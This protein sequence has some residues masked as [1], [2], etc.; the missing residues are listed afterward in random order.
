MK[1]KEELEKPGFE[2]IE[3]LLEDDK[4]V[5]IIKTKVA[6]E[7]LKIDSSRFFPDQKIV[8]TSMSSFEMTIQT[9]LLSQ[10]EE[11]ENSTKQEQESFPILEYASMRTDD[12][13]NPFKLTIEPLKLDIPT[14][15]QEQYLNCFHDYFTFMITE[16]FNTIKNL[17]Q[18]EKDVD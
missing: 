10:E 17:L 9:I 7:L 12:E 2:T 8:Y 15:I 18:G 5:E 14:D 13:T 3:K 1:G 4:I 16:V 11:F 6:E